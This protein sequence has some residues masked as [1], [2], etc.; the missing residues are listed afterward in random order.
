L[1]FT[2]GGGSEGA[3]GGAGAASA[4]N[5]PPQVG[6]FTRVPISS[7]GTRNLR[8]QDGQSTTRVMC[9]P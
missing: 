6:H 8:V 5:T 1:I 9:N 4:L 2:S 7:S 3:G